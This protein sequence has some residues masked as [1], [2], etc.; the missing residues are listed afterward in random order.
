M[1]RKLL[2][3]LLVMLAAPAFLEAAE[4]STSQ[5]EEI[6]TTA[7]RVW[8]L[9]KDVDGWPGWNPAVKDARLVK[10]DGESRGTEL[11]FT[12][13]INGR[14]PPF[15]IS[16]KLEQSEKN[17]VLEYR[18]DSIGMNVVFGFRI[19]EKEGKCLVTSYET[20]SG[21]GAVVFK[22]L[23]GQEGLDQEHRTWVEAIKAK[24]EEP[25]K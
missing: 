20:I 13:T 19:E 12:P 15:K 7:D 23:F 24:L 11:E 3:A 9:L 1:E 6:K 18:S 17:A 14:N 16:L 2:V 4:L 10:G 21:I 5:S 25:E 8:A 22:R